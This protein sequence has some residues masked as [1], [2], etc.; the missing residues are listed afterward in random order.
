MRLNGS[1]LGVIVVLKYKKEKVF[2]IDIRRWHKECPLASD[3]N[4]LIYF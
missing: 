1:E 2:D 4:G 3:S